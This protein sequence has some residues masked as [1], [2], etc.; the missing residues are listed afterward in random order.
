MPL[1]A[2]AACAVLVTAATADSAPQRPAVEPADE[3]VVAPAPPTP[4]PPSAPAAAHGRNVDVR[5]L[6][7]QLPPP[8]RKLLAGEM[9]QISAT[10]GQ[11]VQE[12]AQGNAAAATA[13]AHRL[14]QGFGMESAIAPE[15]YQALTT[16]LPDRYLDLERGYRA[17]LEQLVQ[18]LEAQQTEAAAAGVGELVKA[19]VRCHTEFPKETPDEK[20]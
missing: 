19:C 13:S 4:A 14:A 17:A 6:R 2:V 18:S 7:A 1:L 8:Y 16:V 3:P 15:L 20:R 10:T 5:Q 12:L 9:Q 11:L